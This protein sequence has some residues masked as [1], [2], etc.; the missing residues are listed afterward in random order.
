MLEHN[1]PWDAHPPLMGCRTQTCPIMMHSSNPIIIN[2]PYLN[3][4]FTSITYT[5]TIIYCMYICS[6]A[7][8]GLLSLVNS[9]YSSS[10]PLLPNLY[11]KT[12]PSSLIHSD[13][14]LHPSYSDQTS[15]STPLPPLLSSPGIPVSVASA[16]GRSLSLV[17]I[18][19]LFILSCNFII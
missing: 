11:Y 14:R 4:T 13:L 10:L 3:L 2:A 1:Q 7:L 15:C 17:F 12:T 18:T 9:I 19:V 16:V 8:A 5:I 6:F